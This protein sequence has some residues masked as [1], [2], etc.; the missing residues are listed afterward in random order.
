VAAIGIPPARLGDLLAVA[1][2]HG[3]EAVVRAHV[4]VGEL[5]LDDDPERVRALRAEVEALGGHVVLRRSTPATDALVWPGL[6][7]VAEELMR[8]VKQELDPTGTLA[9]GRHAHEAAA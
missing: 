5:R 9:P 3:A 1:G 2:R 6:D 8:A 4:G 7:P